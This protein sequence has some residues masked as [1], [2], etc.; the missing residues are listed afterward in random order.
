M[1][2]IQV[3]GSLVSSHKWENYQTGFMITFDQTVNIKESFYPTLSISEL[4]SDMGG[5]SGLWLGVGLLQVFFFFLDFIIYIKS[6]IL[7]K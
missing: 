1:S 3:Y 7:N 4:I 6:K 2:L 5:S